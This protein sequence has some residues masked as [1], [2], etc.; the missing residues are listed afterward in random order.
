MRLQPV[1]PDRPKLRVEVQ[2]SVDRNGPF[3]G[4]RPASPIEPQLSDSPSG[5]CRPVADVGCKRNAVFQRAS[6]HLTHV[7][8]KTR[9]IPISSKPW[10]SKTPHTGCDPTLRAPRS[11]ALAARLARRCPKNYL[12]FIRSV[13]TPISSA[14]FRCCDGL[15]DTTSTL[16]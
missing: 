9:Q 3:A 10:G 15:N 1:S 4:H 12:P 6:M 2:S 16:N 11:S 13:A 7:Y 8:C 14:T 5:R